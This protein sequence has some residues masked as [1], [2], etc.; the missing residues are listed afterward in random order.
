MVKRQAEPSLTVG[1]EGVTL[2]LF[3]NEICLQGQPRKPS[4]HSK[5]YS[6]PDVSGRS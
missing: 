3:A 1:P 6:L 5:R 2:T 4:S